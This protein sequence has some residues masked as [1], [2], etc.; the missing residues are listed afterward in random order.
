MTIMTVTSENARLKWRE[1]I[2]AAYADKKS[3]VIE[4]YNKPVAVL[5]NYEHWQRLRALEIAQLTRQRYEEMKH[6]PSLVVTEEQYQ[7][8]L[9][10]E[11]LTA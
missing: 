3:I 1:T 9:Q 10:A 4:R 11:G 8:A 7:Q 2:D 6:N 5:M